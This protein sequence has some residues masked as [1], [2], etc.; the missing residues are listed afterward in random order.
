[1]WEGEHVAAVLSAVSSGSP[2][3]VCSRAC[4]ESTA[5]VLLN[6]VTWKP[7][8]VENSHFTWGEVVGAV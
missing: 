1:M 7:V 2:E 6:H 8:T 5:P 4:A 3:P